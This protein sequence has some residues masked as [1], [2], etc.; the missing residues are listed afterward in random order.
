MASRAR[1]E[2]ILEAKS[3]ILEA[4]RE[5][6]IF[7]VDFWEGS[8][9]WRDVFGYAKSTA[10][11][12]GAL[13]CLTRLSILSGCG[14]FSGSAIPPTPRLFLSFFRFFFVRRGGFVGGAAASGVGFGGAA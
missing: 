13:A 4:K 1:L 2:A 9:E 10:S 6:F 14:G 3:A 12:A 7:Y 11:T 8:V 5:N